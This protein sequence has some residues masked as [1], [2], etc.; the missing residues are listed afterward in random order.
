MMLLRDII[1]NV[2]VTG[3]YGSTD[4]TISGIQFD[5]RKVTSGNVFFAVAATSKKDNETQKRNIVIPTNLVLAYRTMRPFP[6]DIF[7]GFE[8][9]VRRPKKRTDDETE[10]EKDENH[11]IT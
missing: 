6:N 5:S 7:G 9:I 8:A 3:I 10:D 4:I 11:G 1:G 2:P